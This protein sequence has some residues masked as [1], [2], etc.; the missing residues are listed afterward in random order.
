ML[1]KKFI[2]MLAKKLADND[3]TN[4]GHHHESGLIAFYEW[5]IEETYQEFE[6]KPRFK[7]EN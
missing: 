7:K 2:N 3:C 1:D 4:T 5:L 6:M